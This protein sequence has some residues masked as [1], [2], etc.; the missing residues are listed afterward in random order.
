MD[1]E[2]SL[3]TLFSIHKDHFNYPE[4]MF[5]ES[6]LSKT[7]KFLTQNRIPNDHGIEHVFAVIK[8]VL[9]ALDCPEVWHLSS[10]NKMEIVLAAF[11]HDVDDHKFFGTTDYLNARTLLDGKSNIN[12]DIEQV[13]KMIDLVSASKRRIDDP[14]LE[15]WMYIPRDADRLEALGFVG[16]ERAF[17]YGLRKGN[18]VTTRETSVCRTEQDLD[19]VANE[20]RFEAYDGKS[21]SIIDHFY[22][23]LL[24]IGR[25]THLVSR[26]SYI[27]QEA[28][29]RNAIVRKFILD[30]WANL[31]QK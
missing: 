8:H 3:A 16:L 13:V 30:F 1:I 21:Q 14:S 29:R 9:N 7:A 4:M 2:T 12:V 31:P 6:V 18:P 5:L 28:E 17:Q 22:D 25:P 11:L 20:F 10:Q 26:N 27:L 24:H 15:S 19:L 23:K